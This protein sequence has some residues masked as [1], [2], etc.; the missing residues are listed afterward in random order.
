MRRRRRLRPRVVAR[1][2]RV[3]R[4]DDGPDGVGVRGRGEG[5]GDVRGVE[6]RAGYDGEVALGA[7]GVGT[8]DEGCDGVVAGEGFGEGE[9]ACSTASTEEEDPHFCCCFS[10]HFYLFV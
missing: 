8:P 4:R 10:G 5:S 1:P 3:Q 2:R 9:G 7:Q 6:G